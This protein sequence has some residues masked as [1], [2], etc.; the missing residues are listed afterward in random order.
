MPP[1]NLVA[2]ELISIEWRISQL[3]KK[4]NAKL[5]RHGSSKFVITAMPFSNYH[6]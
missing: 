1:D 5:I 2:F 3:P 4:V 6:G